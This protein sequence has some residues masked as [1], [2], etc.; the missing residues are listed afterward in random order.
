MLR[1]GRGS[2]HSE[3]RGMRL[4]DGRLW[5]SLL[6]VISF[7]KGQTKVEKR[8]ICAASLLSGLLTVGPIIRLNCFYYVFAFLLLPQLFMQPQT[9]AFLFIFSAYPQDQGQG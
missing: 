5:Q 2:A 4:L 6:K 9:F 3:C 8:Y 7:V 1:S